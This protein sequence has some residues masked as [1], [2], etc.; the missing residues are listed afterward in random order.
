MKEK[1]KINVNDVV[2]N[3]NCVVFGLLVYTFFF[4]SYF[5]PIKNVLLNNIG[6]L[7]YI[8]LVSSLVGIQTIFWLLGKILLRKIMGKTKEEEEISEAKRIIRLKY[9]KERIKNE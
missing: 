4:S 8:I 5:K 1:T 3:L 2:S 9:K 6:D 7:G